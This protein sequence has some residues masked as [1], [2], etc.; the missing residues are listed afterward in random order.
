MIGTVSQCS[1][2]RHFR[3]PFDTVGKDDASC[4]AFTDVIPREV[5]F[6]T[7]DHREPIEGD[8]G[9]RWESNG[10]RHPLALVPT[11]REA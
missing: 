3:S 5:Y 7:L 9:V 11:H 8:N 2:C 4:A 1:A 10:Q 6:N